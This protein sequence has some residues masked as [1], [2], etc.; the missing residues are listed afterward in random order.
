MQQ[1]LRTTMIIDTI[2]NK[3]LEYTALRDLLYAAQCCSQAFDRGV[4]HLFFMVGPNE[5]YAVSTLFCQVCDMLALWVQHTA[6]PRCW[7]MLADLSYSTHQCMV[8]KAHT[9]SCTTQ[10]NDQAAPAAA[11]AASGQT[12]L[13]TGLLAPSHYC[14]HPSP[15]HKDNPSSDAGPR[16]SDLFS[17]L[18]PASLQPLLQLLLQPPSADGL[19]QCVRL[20]DSLSVPA[21]RSVTPDVQCVLEPPTLADSQAHASMS[22]ISCSWPQEEDWQSCVDSSNIQQVIGG[23][24]QPEH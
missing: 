23:C 17:L 18:C 19:Q 5:C 12:H 7:Q 9:I 8:A 14:V 13:A 1:Q 24:L 2:I 4:R 11:V 16:S 6:H 21:R 3:D 20:L 10:H 15:L 22:H